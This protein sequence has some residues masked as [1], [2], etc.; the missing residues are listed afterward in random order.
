MRENMETKYCVYCGTKYDENYLYC[1]KCGNKI[2]EQPEQT[3]NTIEPS[4]NDTINI[5]IDNSK[6]TQQKSG[7]LASTIMLIIVIIL[8]A[9]LIAGA[10]D[11]QFE[12]SDNSYN[13]NNSNNDGEYT[14]L[15]RSATSNDIYMHVNYDFTIS[16]TP[17]VDIKNLDITFTFYDESDTLITTQEKTFG[18][19]NANVTYDVNTSLSLVELFQSSKVSAKV[20]GGTVSYFA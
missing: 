1:P 7:C 3:Q 20:T 10:N 13:S 15:S 18:N 9:C 2:E 8:F 17:N 5:D 19:V 12:S 16:I 4:P 11:C 6:D 14:L